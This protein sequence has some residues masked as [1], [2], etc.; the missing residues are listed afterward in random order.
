MLVLALESD[1][2]PPG[3]TRELVVSVALQGALLQHRPAPPAQHWFSQL[4]ALLALEDEPVLGYTAPTPLTR[5]HL[6]LRRCG[7]H[8]RPPPLPLRVLVTAETL[9][10]TSSSVPDTS[11]FLLRLLVDDGA[12]LLSDR[13]R[14]P[15]LELQ[16]DFICV[17]DVDFLE[18]LLSS[19]KGNG[20]G[21]S[22]PCP[23]DELLDGAA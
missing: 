18:L 16:R 21:Q 12:V 10:V 4:L 23:R 7:L 14:E 15:R 11:T 17:L 22:P 9:S 1:L 3:D 13:W 20:E 5:L 19:W 8:Y 2:S 6:H